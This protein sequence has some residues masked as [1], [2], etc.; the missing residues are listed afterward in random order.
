MLEWKSDELQVD[1]A[2]RRLVVWRTIGGR[3]TAVA[4]LRSSS[5]RSW[6]KQVHQ[7]IIHF[8]QEHHVSGAMGCWR[9]LA[10]VNP[11]Q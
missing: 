6:H 4:G 2:H 9:S 5:L 3:T 8:P 1:A 7:P 11:D 10:P